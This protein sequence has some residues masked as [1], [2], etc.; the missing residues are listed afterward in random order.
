MEL[1]LAEQLLMLSYDDVTGKPSIA[2]SHLDY[3]LTAA[4]LLDLSYAGMLTV[5]RQRL[6]ATDSTDP[7]PELVKVRA[8]RPHTAD[9]WVYHQTTPQRRQ[10]LLDRLVQAGLLHRDEHRVMGVFPVRAYPETDPAQERELIAALRRLVTGAATPDQ[11]SAGLL[12]IVAACGLD[13]KLFPDLDPQV[14]RHRINELTQGEWCGHA[15]RRAIDAM[16]V[17][18]LA[19]ISGG[20]VSS[21]IGAV[22]A[23]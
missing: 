23:T 11:H 3:G 19:A 5:E 20:I 9:W 16:N 8:H 15:V 14:T 12:A 21:D 10:D 13:R 22:P 2:A 7:D 1:S 4:H 17:A 18:V 6:V